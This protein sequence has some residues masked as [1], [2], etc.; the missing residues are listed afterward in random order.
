[1]F[2]PVISSDQGAVLVDEIAIFYVAVFA[3]FYLTANNSITY[4]QDT[5]EGSIYFSYL[6]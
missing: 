4:P 5:T 6:V 2:K 1:M 3:V